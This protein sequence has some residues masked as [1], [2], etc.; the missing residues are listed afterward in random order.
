MDQQSS[1]ISAF[2][3]KLSLPQRPTEETEADQRTAVDSKFIPNGTL[4]DVEV[5][6][7][8]AIQS[9]GLSMETQEENITVYELFSKGSKERSWFDETIFAEDT[10]VEQELAEDVGQC[11]S[12]SETAQE[13]YSGFS[14][15]EWTDSSQVLTVIEKQA[16][17]IEL[18]FQFIWDHLFNSYQ[19]LFGL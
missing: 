19:K 8:G 10:G 9:K 16:W 15:L 7:T 5:T 17:S 2:E 12:Y 6:T 13:N 4:T 14:S 3:D 1:K 11:E 18:F